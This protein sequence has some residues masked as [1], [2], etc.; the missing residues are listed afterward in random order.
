PIGPIFVP[1]NI[2]RVIVLLRNP[3]S[4]LCRLATLLGCMAMLP[5]VV[6]ASGYMLDRDPQSG[7]LTFILC[8]S[9]GPV[10]APSHRDAP[11]QHAHHSGH[12]SHHDGHDPG[13]HDKSNAATA[14]DCAFALAFAPL[15][16]ASP[17]PDTVACGGSGERPYPS[18]F[19]L[20]TG[21][22]S[23]SQRARAP[24]EHS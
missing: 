7:E 13:A 14:G 23:W 11:G 3:G 10:P 24:P 1:A 6:V 17:A 4:R 9:Q 8:P 2:W 12:A 20:T 18:A 5:H 15:A 22:S 21:D 16:G 19:A